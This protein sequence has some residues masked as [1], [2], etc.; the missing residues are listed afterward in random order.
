MK[1]IVCNH[2]D[3][4]IFKPSHMRLSLSIVITRFVF[5]GLLLSV[6]LT[7]ALAWLGPLVYF[8]RDSSLLGDVN[9]V[10]SIQASGSL[11]IQETVTACSFSSANIREFATSQFQN[12]LSAPSMWKAFGA[13]AYAGNQLPTSK[14]TCSSHAARRV[15]MAYLYMAPVF[16]QLSKDPECRTAASLRVLE[17][18]AAV[19][20]AN[21]SLAH[22]WMHLDQSDSNLTQVDVAFQQPLFEAPSIDTVSSMVQTAS[23][24][25]SDSVV[26]KA[27]TGRD[28]YES[29]NRAYGTNTFVSSSQ[30]GA[31]QFVEEVYVDGLG[32]CKDDVVTT[33]LPGS[34]H[35]AD[36]VMETSTE[37]GLLSVLKRFCLTTGTWNVYDTKQYYTIP[38]SDGVDKD[39]V[40][41]SNGDWP[42]PYT[43]WMDDV[44]LDTCSGVNMTFTNDATYECGLFRALKF[45]SHAWSVAFVAYAPAV[46]LCG[47]ATGFASIS[48]V[49]LIY[50]L[51]IEQCQRSNR[52]MHMNLPDL[53]I[54][55]PSLMYTGTLWGLYGLAYFVG[56]RPTIA[57]SYPRPRCSSSSGEYYDR[58]QA[59]TWKSSDDNILSHDAAVWTLV[60]VV[61]V[62]LLMWLWQ[63]AWS[64]YTA[65]SQIKSEKLSYL[66]FVLKL[67]R[68]EKSAFAVL[69]TVGILVYVLLV[70]NVL[71][72]HVVEYQ[73]KMGG[74][75]TS[76][77]DMHTVNKA[78]RDFFWFC[79]LGGAWIA[80][81]SRS[82]AFLVLPSNSGDSIFSIFAELMLSPSLLAYAGSMVGIGVGCYV[83][84]R[85]VWFEF[86]SKFNG[87][88]TFAELVFWAVVA[89]F[90]GLGVIALCNRKR[91]ARTQSDTGRSVSAGADHSHLTLS[92]MAGSFF[93]TVPFVPLALSTQP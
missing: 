75:F 28:I 23:L 44:N 54:V 67:M 27:C 81:A 76:A 21:A 77:M 30:Y 14:V 43:W 24:L 15:E 49:T 36:Y 31:A 18:E 35:L 29:C 6:A 93:P 51:F 86:D 88:H 40:Q 84:Q 25:M 5:F 63:T 55:F 48:I 32:S 79:A 37:H 17:P 58:L 16:R 71:A 42:W 87:L 33:P 80:V 85:S 90:V 74:V 69:S 7:V 12:K 57:L 11:G 9:V 41:N 1:Y 20:N 56:V 10:S 82:S 13:V 2:T 61:G 73:Q 3:C 8:N 45:V 46:V 83:L 38:R 64:A 59:G 70:S 4:D 68:T 72:T 26:R 92:Q 47:Y 39:V 78:S 50:Y 53:P 34:A 62:F 19:Y 22:F 91:N 65:S 52:K 89:S 60:A 66:K